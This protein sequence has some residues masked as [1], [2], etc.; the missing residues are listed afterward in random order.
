MAVC[1][2]FCLTRAMRGMGISLRISAVCTNMAISF[3]TI[4]T[5]IV[6]MNSDIVSLIK[7]IILFIIACNT[8]YK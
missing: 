8:V 6:K 1:G 4:N 7:N 2:K 3:F 5:Y